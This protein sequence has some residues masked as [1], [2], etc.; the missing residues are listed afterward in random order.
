MALRP[1]PSDGSTSHRPRRPLP[2]Q[3]LVDRKRW[4][5]LYLSTAL[6]TDPAYGLA[7]TTLMRS[8]PALMA[9][10]PL[11]PIIR[12]AGVA[13]AR[14]FLASYRTANG[15]VSHPQSQT[16]DWYTSLHALRIL[17]EFDGWRWDPAGIDHSA[18]PWIALSPLA[19]P[20]AGPRPLRSSRYPHE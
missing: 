9:P 15:E 12:V 20:S 14:R 7:S 18:H 2:V 8:H 3:L 19:S 10:A 4:T 6:V 5:L 11:R 17:V 1:S 16:M 13:I